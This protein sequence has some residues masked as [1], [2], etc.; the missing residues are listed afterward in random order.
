LEDGGRESREV[1]VRQ[2][3]GGERPEAGEGVVREDREVVTS[4]IE[5][6]EAR[7]KAEVSLL[8]AGDL[9]E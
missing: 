7:D 2:I 5:S 1:I 4:E 6:C 8:E 3:N 9:V